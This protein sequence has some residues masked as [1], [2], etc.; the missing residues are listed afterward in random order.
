MLCEGPYETH[1]LPEFLQQLPRS[2]VIV[3]TAAEAFSERVGGGRARRL[4]SQSELVPERVHY[5]THQG[6]NPEKRPPYAT[7][8]PC[9]MTKGCRRMSCES[10]CAGCPPLS[11]SMRGAERS[12][13]LGETRADSRR[14]AWPSRRRIRKHT[15]RRM[16]RPVSFAS[17]DVPRR[18]ARFL[19]GGARP[20]SPAASQRTIQTAL[21]WARRCPAWRRTAMQH[22]GVLALATRSV[23]RS[24]KR[25]ACSGSRRCG[26]AGWPRRRSSRR[27]AS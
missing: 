25:I 12:G 26:C 6:G 8:C 22:G 19:R 23:K 17:R 21:R 14:G 27:T 3:E 15:T 16:R 18:R 13:A 11:R 20:C 1:S 5:E 10:V 7:R 9:D 4:L 2:R 24:V